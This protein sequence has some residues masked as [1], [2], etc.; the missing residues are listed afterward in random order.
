MIDVLS[1][2]KA[3][4]ES[5]MFL[6]AVEFT[7]E[8]V[9]Y[10]NSQDSTAIYSLERLSILPRHIQ[11]NDVLIFFLQRYEMQLREK[12]A[13]IVATRINE[14]ARAISTAVSKG[15][16]GHRPPL[17][18][19]LVQRAHAV[20]RRR[21]RHLASYPLEITLNLSTALRALRGTVWRCWL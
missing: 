7:Q 8:I 20:S 21:C 17:H 5:P 13:R 12:F 11:G 15:P 9:E 6:L 18:R 3:I 4:S 1:R 2:G 16:R 19:G 10:T 14:T